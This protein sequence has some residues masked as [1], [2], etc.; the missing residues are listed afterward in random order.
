MRNP[1]FRK[2]GADRERELELI[3]CYERE[4]N[5][6]EERVDKEHKVNKVGAETDDD[7]R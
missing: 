3:T 6:S 1:K 4:V 2:V 7:L 5:I